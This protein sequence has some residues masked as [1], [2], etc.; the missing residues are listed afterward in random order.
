M[1]TRNARLRMVTVRGVLVRSGAA[2][3]AALLVVALTPVA[4]AAAG[5]QAVPE[6]APEAGAPPGIAATEAD[7]TPP[8]STRGRWIVDADGDRFKLR[9]GNWHG[10]SDTWNGS[11][12]P[13]TDADHH[14]GENSGRMPLGLD[15]APMAEIIAGFQEI[16]I[17]SVRLPF[18]NEMIHD[19]RPVTDE[20]VAAN[21][22][23]RGQK[24][25]QGTPA[26]TTAAPPEPVRPP[27]PA[28]ATSAPPN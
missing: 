19:S 16:G 14:A 27:T 3:A 28:T 12:S 18:S 26:R 11:G 13:D 6:A 24:P 20:S 22:S 23:L 21:P 15:R 9:S 2:L 5:G 8:L 25:L 17:N 7:W 10:A 1:T 4:E